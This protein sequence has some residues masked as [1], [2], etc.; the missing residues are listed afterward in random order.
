MVRFQIALTTDEADA[1]FKLSESNLRSPRYQV[2]FLVRKELVRKKLL[3]DE[4]IDEL[5]SKEQKDIVDE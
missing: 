5:S 3:F 4:E 2:R 1:L